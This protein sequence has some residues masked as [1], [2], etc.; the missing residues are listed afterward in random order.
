MNTIVDIFIVLF[1]IIGTFL[2]TKK[3]LIKSAVGFIGL[4]AIIILSYTF[5]TYLANFL[6]DVMPFFQFS[7]AIAGL[8]SLNVL[9]Y[10]VI[11]FIVI[12]I[13]M[14]CILNIVISLTGFIDTLLKFTV[15]W[16]IPSK[17]GGAIIGL[18]ESWVFLYLAVFVLAQFNGTNAWI[19]ESKVGD[20]ILNNTPVIGTYLSDAGDAAQDI[21]DTIELATKENVEAQTL[22]LRIL[23][24]EIKYGLITKEKAQ[25]LIQTGKI[26]IKGVM[27]GY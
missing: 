26:P 8:T 9:I 25:E 18:L 10:N 21:Y 20:F 7:G 14:Y 16:I 19:S 3:G 5:K 24:I 11:S 27:F 13:L 1:I 15:I 6:I 17:I 12:F 4:V 23:Q 22:D 2:G